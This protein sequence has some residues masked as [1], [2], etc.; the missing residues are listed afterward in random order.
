MKRIIIAAMLT[1][2]IST[3]VF[4]QQKRVTHPPVSLVVPTPSATSASEHKFVVLVVES[5]HI[6]HDGAPISAA[7]LVEY[8]NTT[9]SA[10]DAPNLAVHLREGI[11]YGDFV[12]AVDVLRKT[13]TKSISI[14]LKEVPLGREV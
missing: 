11:T 14:S 9:M 6:S 4:A 7:G 5:T 1:L 3:G 8:L 13:N 2:G 10:E 12:N